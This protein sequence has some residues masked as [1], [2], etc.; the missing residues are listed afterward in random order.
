MTSV[1]TLSLPLRGA[2][3]LLRSAQ[4]DEYPPLTL[5]VKCHSGITSMQNR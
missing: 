5:R 4:C 1:N 2:A 3:D